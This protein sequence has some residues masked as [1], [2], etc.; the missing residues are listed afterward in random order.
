MGDKRSGGDF[1]HSSE[2]D[3]DPD[4]QRRGNQPSSFDTNP[5]IQPVIPSASADEDSEDKT[6]ELT[7][8]MQARIAN[9]PLP[10]AQPLPGERRSRRL[11]IVSI[12]ALVAVLGATLFVALRGQ[13]SGVLGTGPDFTG[14][15][16][17]TPCQMANAYLANYIA[18]RYDQMYD[19]VSQQ[20]IKRFDDQRILR[21]NYKDA[22]DYIANRTKDI[23]ARA[24]ITSITASPG[25]PEKTGATT[26]TVSARMEFQSARV[27]SFEQDINIPLVFENNHWRIVWTPG[28]IF[29]HL[30]DSSDPY[31]AHKVD[32]VAQDGQRGAIYDSDGDVLAKDDTVYDITVTASKLT[33]KTAELTTL[34]KDL[35]FTVDQ[36]NQKLSGASADQPVTIRTITAQLY[37]QVSGDLGKL[38]GVAA[39][40]DTGRVYPY[41]SVMAPVTGYVGPVTAD[42]IK[43]DKTG[44]YDNPN[45]VIGKTG[46]ERWGEQYL[47]P[48]HGGKLQ[49]FETNA[50]GSDGPVVFTVASRVPSN[51]ADVHT[52]I[53][54]KAQ[55]AAMTSLSQQDG[56]S[57]GTMA[58]DP[59]TGA[60]LAMGTFPTYNPTDLSLGLTPNAYNR[61]NALDAPFINR[62]VASAQPTGSV[63]KLFTL[64]AGL[65]NGVSASRIFTCTGSYQ[66]PGEAKPRADDRPQGHGNITAPYA[67]TPS[68]DVVFWQIAVELNAKDP[69]LLPTMA[70][71]FGFGVDA[72]IVGV[73]KSDEKPG[74]VPDPAYM[75]SNNLG[76][77]SPTDAANL[78]IGQGFFQATPAQVTLAT[79][80][81]ADNGVRMQPRLVSSVVSTS[82]VTIAAF[83]A[84]QRGTLPVSAENLATIQAAMLGPL[85][86][87]NGTAHDDVKDIPVLVAGK[88]GTAESGQAHPNSW[89][90]LYAPASPA[91]GPPVAPQITVSSLVERSDFGE[92]FAFPV[93]KA[94]LKA[95]LGFK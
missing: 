87:P 67:L 1:R 21:G 19:L 94:V 25:S 59:T 26:A 85:Y 16:D 4:A 27:G 49:I 34:G 64:A 79:A 75:Q 78:G 70:K 41:G 12:V 65:Q 5:A 69:N 89:F 8:E 66:V 18:G 23:L 3:T 73:P 60:V 55:Q 40:K 22:H 90:T 7:P 76:T 63:F 92:K 47:R 45:D 54:L 48:T 17:N 84:T 14:C 36:L 24:Q 56:H 83:D 6:T 93:C 30:D 57:G 61:L 86:D 58:V 74:I 88:T 62:A 10:K 38:A 2:E 20:T 33:D 42:D 46:V 43:N 68:C 11:V 51:G 13:G 32:L 39:Q 31:Y 80:A 28:L 35:D 72:D 52:T 82:G 44:Y 53:S 9:E 71:A 91:S 37:Q 81:I 29:T 15:G 77:W 50:D 95:Y